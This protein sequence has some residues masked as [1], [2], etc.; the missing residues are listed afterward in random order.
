MAGKDKVQIQANDNSIEVI[1]HQVIDLMGKDGV[2]LASEKFIRLQVGAHMVQMTPAGGI[3]F[4]SPQAL[5]AQTSSMALDAPQSAAALTSEWPADSLNEMFVLRN[6]HGKP[7]AHFPYVI[8][9]EDGRV[10]RGMTNKLGQ[11]ERVYTGD[12]PLKMKIGP[13]TQN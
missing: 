11:A 5:K 6:Q 10:I 2:H 8:E 3:E 13:D 12:K 4:M 9:V 7:M 1:A